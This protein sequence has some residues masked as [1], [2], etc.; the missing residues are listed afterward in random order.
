MNEFNK[1]LQLVPFHVVY[2]RGIQQM[3][4]VKYLS[5][6]RKTA[7]IFYRLRKAKTV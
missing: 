4:S 2:V 1:D 7:K 6:K 5:E 3:F